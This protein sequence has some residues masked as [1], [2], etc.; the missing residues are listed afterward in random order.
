MAAPGG[1]VKL[2][3]ARRELLGLRREVGGGRGHLTLELDG[4]LSRILLD[5]PEAHNAFGIQMML[6]LAEAV[7]T[8]RSWE[9]RAVLL[10]S[11]KPGMFCSGGDLLALRK[12]MTPERGQRMAMAMGSTLDHLLALPLV[13][14]AVVEG[15]AMG[16]GAELATACDFRVMS[17]RA[18]IQFVQ[19][20]LGVAA[21]WGGAGR[22][23]RH[24]GPR[25]ALRLLTT[26]APLDAEA[27]LALGLAD[28]VFDGRARPAALEFLAPMMRMPVAA[29]AALKEQVTAGWPP[30][31]PGAV[32]AEAAAFAR[33]W[34][35]PEHLSALKKTLDKLGIS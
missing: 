3:A 31:A 17:R 32:G 26:A 15:V 27:A 20:R 14:V 16:G 2:G 6:D 22:L 19:A 5:N 25:Q 9:G 21:G 18:R 10:C 34:G 35:G 29:I 7:S 4:E 1:A 13:S 24:I 8:L 11:A 33:V 28:A 23:V 30:R 12:L